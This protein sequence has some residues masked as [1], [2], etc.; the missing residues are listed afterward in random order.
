MA[1]IHIK[2]RATPIELDFERARKLKQRKYGY[3]GISKA[4]NTDQVDLGEW[5]GQYGEI[6]SIDTSVDR[7]RR[8]NEKVYSDQECIEFELELKPFLNKDGFLASDGEMR[9]LQSERVINFKSKVDGEVKTA[10]DFD[11]GIIQ[12]KINDYRELTEKIDS[13]KDYIE[14]K[15]YGKNK[16]LE[17]TAKKSGV[18]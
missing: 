14:R 17:E 6:I 10:S 2:K 5:A 18:E 1:L 11:M 16:G 12:D 3:D 15:N 8:S 7:S 13:W 9:F 4:E